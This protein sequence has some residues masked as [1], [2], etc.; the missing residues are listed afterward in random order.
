MKKRYLLPFVTLLAGASLL[1]SGCGPKET[2][3]D[4]AAAPATVGTTDASGVKTFEI[5]GA[6]NM[7][8]NITQLTAAPGEEIKVVFTNVG[9]QPK[10]AMGHNWVLLKKDTDVTAFDNA[11]L[12]SKA[13]DYIPEE[14]KDEIIAHTK[15]LGA[16]ESDTITF[17]APA[18]PGDYPYLCTFPAHYQVGMK[19]VLTVK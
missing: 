2:A 7:K 18:E 8:F 3:S 5:T 4:S 13:T 14:K 11:A 9:T 10:V 16:K 6:D 17:K 12:Q 15:L 19:G 1:L